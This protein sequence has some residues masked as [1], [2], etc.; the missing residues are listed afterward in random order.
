MVA[1]ASVRWFTSE[2]TG[3]PGLTNVAGA[4]VQVLDACL[5]DGFD[6]K[7]I[8]SLVVSGGVATASIGAGHGYAPGVVVRIAGATP[9]GLNRDWKVATAT[10]TALTFD[11][12]GT[13]VADGT[14]TGTITALRAPV[15][16]TRQFSSGNK[17]VYAPPPH[18]ILPSC[19]LRVDDTGTQVAAVSGYVTM[20]NIDTGTEPFPGVATYWQKSNAASPRSWLIAGDAEAIVFCVCP[21]S[22]Y[23][24][25]GSAFFFGRLLGYSTLDEYP[26]LLCADLGTSVTTQG[27][28]YGLGLTASAVTGRSS[29]PRGFSGAHGVVDAKYS[30]LFSAE[31]VNAGSGTSGSGS[32]YAPSYAGGADVLYPTPIYCS[33]DKLRGEIPGVLGL[34][35][36]GAARIWPA[37]SKLPWQPGE[38]ELVVFPTHYLPASTTTSANGVLFVD[39][40]GPWR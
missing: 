25:N 3:A 36:G 15:G 4:L 35:Q 14:A 23:P 30:I 37:L 5:V 19:L 34:G 38:R 26:V 16:W 12:S 21:A 8:D 17:R 6:P 11:V 28:S 33:A 22:A 32:K 24:E 9:A 29:L 31:S 39:V 13:G 40:T 10:A 18:P 2:M 7:V 27:G 1:D 20:S